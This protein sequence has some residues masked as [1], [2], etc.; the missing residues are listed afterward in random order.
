[1]LL[2]SVSPAQISDQKGFDLLSRPLESPKTVEK[3]SNVWR[4][5][6]CS[7]CRLK[8]VSKRAMACSSA[9]AAQISE[10]RRYGQ[11]NMFDLLSGPSFSLKKSLPRPDVWCLLFSSFSSANSKLHKDPHMFCSSA[12]ATHILDPKGDMVCRLGHRRSKIQSLVTHV[13]LLLLCSIL[14]P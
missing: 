6:F 8:D 7:L 9:S 11:R 5:L 4:L 2:V 1:M 13:W 12:S 10:Q 14:M 3:V